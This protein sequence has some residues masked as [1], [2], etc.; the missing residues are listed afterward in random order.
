MHSKVYEEFERICAERKIGGSVLEV[1]AIPSDSS[2]LC[3]KALANAKEK[4]GV[5]LDGPC[6]FR[7]FKIVKGN[8]NSLECFEDNRFDAVVCN[9]T[10]EHDKYFWKT[11]VDRAGHTTRRTVRH[12]RAGLRPD[13]G[14]GRGIGPAKNPADTP[15]PVTPLLQSNV[16]L[17]TH[18]SNPQSS[19]RLLSLQSA[20]DARSVF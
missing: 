11:I 12:W 9:A 4:I 8:A 19:G 13:P 6:E 18:P 17:N 20:S 10:L 7:D 3:M 2:L 15:A 1:G 5:N 16:C 14:R